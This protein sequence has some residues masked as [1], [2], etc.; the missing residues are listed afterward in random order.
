MFFHDLFDVFY[1]EKIKGG[2]LS[3]EDLLC[4]RSV[5]DLPADLSVMWNPS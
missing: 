2:L 3:L 1:R 5:T 4:L